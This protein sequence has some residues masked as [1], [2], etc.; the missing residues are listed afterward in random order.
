MCMR[1][2]MACITLLF[3]T[4]TKFERVYLYTKRA[5]T[6]APSAARKHFHYHHHLRGTRYVGISIMK[7]SY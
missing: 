7:K 4:P 3:V 5:L 6:F 1:H 2:L